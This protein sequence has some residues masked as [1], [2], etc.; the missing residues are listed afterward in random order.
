[1]FKGGGRT[2]DSLLN[3]FGLESDSDAARILTSGVPGGGSLGVASS[4]DVNVAVRGASGTGSVSHVAMRGAGVAANPALASGGRN[5]G[6]EVN[7]ASYV[8]AAQ[9]T[10][11]EMEAAG[12]T[13]R[14]DLKVGIANALAATNCNPSSKFKYP[15]AANAENSPK[16][17]PATIFGWNFSPMS[18]A[19]IAEWRN[20]AGCVTLVCFKASESSPNIISEIRNPR[21]S[22][23]F[24]NIF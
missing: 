3:R 9:A 16:E 22:L 14:E 10:V 8:L 2:L 19:K 12:F 4:S 5:M 13:S 7:R 24:S 15:D 11:G 23:A 6:D 21:I 1:M 18:L 20:I 17:C